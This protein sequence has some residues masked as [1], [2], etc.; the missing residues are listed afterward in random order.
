[1]QVKLVV[2][3]LSIQEEV[4]SA[5]TFLRSDEYEDAE[6]NNKPEN[7]KDLIS[8][9]NIVDDEAS[10]GSTS[11]DAHTSSDNEMKQGQN[12]D[13]R[14][15]RNK[16]ETKIRNIEKVAH[17]IDI[18]TKQRLIDINIENKHKTKNNKA[19]KDYHT[20]DNETK[21][22]QKDGNIK[23][24]P[25][26]HNLYAEED[27]HT[28][29]FEIKKIQNNNESTIEDN[30]KIK[31]VNAQKRNHAEDE[32]TKLPQE[33]GENIT[34]KTESNNVQK[35]N[36]AN[37]VDTKP[38][39]KNKESNIYNNINK[40][41]SGIDKRKA[42]TKEGESNI[43]DK[44]Q[45]ISGDAGAEPSLTT[46]VKGTDKDAVYH[47]GSFHNCTDSTAT[48]AI[49]L[50][51][52]GES[53]KVVISCHEI[54]FRA[55]LHS[56]QSDLNI[57]VGV[58]SSAGGSGPARR[59]SIRSTWAS[60]RT[61]VF[62]L[63]AGPWSEEIA[64]EYNKYDDL[65]WIDEEEVYDGERS[66]LTF[67]TYAFIAIAQAALAKYGHEYTHLFKTDDD[68][69]L[70]LNA[71]HHEFN[72]SEDA[73][74]K[75]KCSRDEERKCNHDF[76]GQCQL[77]NHRVHREE[78][79]K[80]P[81][82]KKSYAEDW[83]PLYCQGAGFALSKKFAECASAQKHIANVRFMPFE[84]VAVGMLAERC[85]II[86]EWPTT[87]KVN[88]DRYHSDEAKLRTRSDD[89]RSNDLVAPPACMNNKIVQHRIINDNDMKEYH[90]AVLDPGYCDV[91]KNEYNT[92]INEK[93]E[94]GETWFD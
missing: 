71:L 38:S 60:G 23:N 18:E 57:I 33:T 19:M 43:D 14:K 32:R 4:P 41:K 1:M 28:E 21:Q 22:H 10:Q 65:L 44:L 94:K 11:K 72:A 13:E 16:P 54:G 66:V 73:P 47:T 70:D 37:T 25:E 31:I 83:F 93:R 3:E 12:D 77:F 56:F 50:D 82:S 24:K 85:G 88:V 26:T 74:R 35:D 67:K 52:S 55:N 51:D 30:P 76:V 36:H 84:D 91:K 49:T 87:A 79:Y 34:H 78:G 59:K 61:G 17:T 64:E 62:F 5:T 80:W 48:S 29:K 58:L 27:A 9:D 86:P 63:V 40:I 7:I 2:T 68:S 81:L 6:E 75:F 39:Q 53:G 90:K 89:K 15:S 8:K 45:T 20:I 42:P 46:D 92:I 69:Y